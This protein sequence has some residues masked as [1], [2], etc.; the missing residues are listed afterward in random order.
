MTLIDVHG[1]FNTTEREYLAKC[2]VGMMLIMPIANRSYSIAIKL[3]T[4][5]IWWA[6]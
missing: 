2:K 6:T 3:S 4:L 1:V 5:T